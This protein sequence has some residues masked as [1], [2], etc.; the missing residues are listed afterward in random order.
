MFTLLGTCAVPTLQIL[1]FFPSMACLGA[2]NPQLFQQNYLAAPKR[3]WMI[4]VDVVLYSL[5]Y[6]VNLKSTDDM[7]GSKIDMK[8]M[9][10]CFNVVF[11]TTM[12]ISS[13]IIGVCLEQ[14]CKQVSIAWQT[15]NNEPTRLVSG[16]SKDLQLLKKVLSPFLFMA[17]SL[18]CILII[19]SAFIVASPSKLPKEIFVPVLISSLWDLYYITVIVDETMD[20]YKSLVRHLRYN[21]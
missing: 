5:V 8:I 2:N 13:F 6:G 9:L 7:L 1:F 14:F 3:V 20:S 21:Y 15:T 12:I 17:F 4:F 18:K 16:L 19:N 11:L 10:N